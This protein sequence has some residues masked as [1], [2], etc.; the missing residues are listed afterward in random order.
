M[1]KEILFTS[2][3]DQNN[4][5]DLRTHV[6][7]IKTLHILQ[8]FTILLADLFSQRGISDIGHWIICVNIKS[9]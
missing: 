7:G 1:S 8:P 5:Y 2:F 3:E 6:W 4:S 9:I